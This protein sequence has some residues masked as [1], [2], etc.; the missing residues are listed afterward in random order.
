MQQR[1]NACQQPIAGCCK[2]EFVAEKTPTV[3]EWRRLYATSGR[4]K[5]MAPWEWMM[6]DEVFGVR[7]PESDEIGFVS[8]MGAGGEHFAVAVYPGADA[9]YQFLYLHEA[10][11][12]GLADDVG[13]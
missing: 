2:G 5:E 12:E 11:A 10:G 8:V 4:V 13:A 3:E 6:E 9:L 7:N 1:N